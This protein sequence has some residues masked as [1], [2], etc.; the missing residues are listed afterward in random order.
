MEI[1]LEIEIARR[2]SKL[3]SFKL[4]EHA[5]TRNRTAPLSDDNAPFPTAARIGKGFG[6]EI[7]RNSTPSLLAI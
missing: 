2:M 3:R 7:A 4:D 5:A 1:G 6:I